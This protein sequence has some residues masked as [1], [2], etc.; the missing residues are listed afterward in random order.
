[1]SNQLFWDI[2]IPLLVGDV[3]LIHFFSIVIRQYLF[4]LPRSF[5]KTLLKIS[6]KSGP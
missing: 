3:S 2:L 6:P 4:S 1:M 5:M